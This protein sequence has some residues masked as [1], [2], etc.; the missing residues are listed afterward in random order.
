MGLEEGGEPECRWEG[1]WMSREGGNTKS[2]VCRAVHVGCAT[3]EPLKNV[4]Q[5]S[6]VNRLA[7][8]NLEGE[9]AGLGPAE[10]GQRDASGVHGCGLGDCTESYCLLIRNTKSRLQELKDRSKVRFCLH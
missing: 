6:G 2:F 4:E 1:R 3:Q 9:S 7:F 10:V 5:R 8:K